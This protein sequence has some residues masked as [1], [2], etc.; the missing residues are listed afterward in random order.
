V[1]QDDRRRQAHHRGRGCA[2]TSGAPGTPRTASTDTQQ[3]IDNWA[4]GPVHL[5]QL[6]KQSRREPVRRLH[7]DLQEPE[8][9]WGTTAEAPAVPVLEWLPR[10]WT[11]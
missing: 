8:S 11:E 9:S 4:T 6:L 7:P 1:A 5:R 2:A 3:K 10:G